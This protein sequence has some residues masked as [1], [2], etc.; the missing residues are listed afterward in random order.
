LIKKRV[1]YREKQKKKTILREKLM[2]KENGCLI[3]IKEVRLKESPNKPKEELSK[4]SIKAEASPD[5]GLTIASKNF[6]K[7]SNWSMTE[8][9]LKNLD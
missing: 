2:L 9:D 8:K 4:R 5:N 7:T 1:K 6:Q 3:S